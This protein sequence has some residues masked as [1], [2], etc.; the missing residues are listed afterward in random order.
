MGHFLELPSYCL[1][2]MKPKK[3]SPDFNLCSLKPTPPSLKITFSIFRM[4]PKRVK[5]SLLSNIWEHPSS[6]QLT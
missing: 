2:V 4:F 1:L 3:K 5:S 6:M